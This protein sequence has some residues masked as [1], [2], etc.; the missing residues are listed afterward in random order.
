MR[1]KIDKSKPN[2]FEDYIKLCENISA[3]AVN[4]GFRSIGLTSASHGE[5]TSTVS[6]NLAMSF[7]KYQKFKTLLIDANCVKPILHKFF[8]FQI[9]LR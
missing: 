9:N 5:G 6:L 7:A 4:N 2:A 3:L 8:N 1:L